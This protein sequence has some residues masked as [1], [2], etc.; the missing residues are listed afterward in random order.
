MLRH[1][2]GGGTKEVLVAQQTK[3]AS[4]LSRRRRKRVEFIRKSTTASVQPTP[5]ELS[6]PDGIDPNYPLPLYNNLDPT[7]DEPL[8]P[9]GI[10]LDYP[11]PSYDNLDPA[12][13]PAPALD[14]TPDTFYQQSGVWRY[15]NS[16]QPGSTSLQSIRL[17]VGDSDDEDSYQT[18]DLTG[19]ADDF[20]S[21]SEEE[22]DD[23][24]ESSDEELDAESWL[25]G[26]SAIQVLEEEFEREAA[27]RGMMPFIWSCKGKANCVYP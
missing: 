19:N 23:T 27:A 25:Q 9:D 7:P 3:L 20:A 11:L 18:S 10:D 4:S 26:M 22:G 12:P 17:T 5:D 15:P 1:L 2:N 13:A 14:S 24:A 16:R 6:P 8:P 21:S